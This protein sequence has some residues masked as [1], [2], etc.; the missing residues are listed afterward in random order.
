MTT[1]A[2]PPSWYPAKTAC[3]ETMTLAERDEL[4]AVSVPAPNHK[5]KWGQEQKGV[6]G[7][8]Q[9]KTTLSPIPIP[10]H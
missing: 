6:L 9:L 8:A 2:G 10:A 4:L 5:R 7:S 1:E 3:P